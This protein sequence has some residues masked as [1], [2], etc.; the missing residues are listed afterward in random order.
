MGWIGG[1]SRV[2]R[3]KDSIDPCKA[4]NSSVS[5]CLSKGLHIE[6]ISP[7]ATSIPLW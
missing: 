3:V 6:K 2:E 4:M 1:S 7:S 5:V